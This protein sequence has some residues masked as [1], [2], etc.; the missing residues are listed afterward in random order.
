MTSRH[1]CITF[2]KEP[3]LVEQHEQIRYAIYGKETCPTTGKVHWQSYIEFYK[4]CR[5]AGVKKIFGDKTLHAEVRRGTREEARDY[6]KKENSFT[7]TGK[8]IKGQGHR[9][10]LESIVGE[11]QEGRK[12]SD[13]MIEQPALYCQYRNGLK[14]ISAAVTKN[15]TKEF[16]KLNVTVLSGP[17]ECGKTR[18]AMEEMKGEGYKILGSKLSWWQDY[19]QEDCI[20]IDE[21]DN[22]VR[23]TE[24]LALLDGYQLRLNVK[25]THTYANWTKVYITT[26]LRWSEIHPNAKPAHRA[27]LWR[28]ITNFVDL[29]DEVP[30]KDFPKIENCNDEVQG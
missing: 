25:G 23:I 29:W 18:K 11:L 3:L 13:L 2:F 19:E 5:I 20:L 10:D 6:C 17:T 26:N 22:D 30:E 15:K 16:R 12:L 14:D 27:A 7:E 9:T 8:W 21:Y 24:L 4:P 28:R 1:Y